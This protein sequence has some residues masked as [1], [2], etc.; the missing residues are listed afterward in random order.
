MVVGNNTSRWKKYLNKLK[1]KVLSLLY[2]STEDVKSTS[3]EDMHCR[4]AKTKVT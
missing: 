2:K 4:I 3:T 1:L